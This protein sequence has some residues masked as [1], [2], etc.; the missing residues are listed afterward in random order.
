[1]TELGRLE[2]I[3]LR[4]VWQDEA[5][6][7]TPWLAQEKNIALLGETL[8]MELEVEAQERN[9]GPF[10]AD[11]LCKD[12]SSDNWVL[13]E[14]QLE[15]TDH[16]H[17]G[18]LITYAAGL[19]AV[20]IVWVANRFTDEHRAALD[21]LNQITD[22][23]F[24]FFGLEVELWKIGSSS[25]APKFNLVS[26]PNNWS[27]SAAQTRKQIERGEMRPVQQLQLEY[28][29][30]MWEL[31]RQR[32]SH[33][34]GTKPRAQHWNNF[35][36]GR[37][38]FRLASIMDTQKKNIR[39][40]II[41]SGSQSFPRYYGLEANR[42]SIESQLGYTLKWQ[43]LPGK[44]MKRISITSNDFDPT[45]KITWEKQ[46]H[47]MLDRLEEFDRIV[48]PIVKSIDIDEFSGMESED[49]DNE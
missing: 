6:D 25:I 16:T 35:S 21:W 17:L 22:D 42:E 8:D 23:D 18:Q 28:W 2:K 1:M 13:I 48:R 12:T 36:L 7:F 49:S 20:T 41:C 27:K 3:N 44:K 30:A 19:D 47:W 37:T 32:G 45:D 40:E 34:R 10:R 9:V 43:E 26:K 14:N 33:L 5:K 29:T 31:I 15:R 24:Q 38:G 46:H 11:I 4:D 39:A